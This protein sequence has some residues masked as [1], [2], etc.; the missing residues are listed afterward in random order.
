MGADQVEA[1]HSMGTVVGVW[2]DHILVLDVQE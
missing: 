1:E 2:E